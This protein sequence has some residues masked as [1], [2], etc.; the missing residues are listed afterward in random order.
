MIERYSRD[1]LDQSSVK[2]NVKQNK[3]KIGEKS[4]NKTWT[5][6]N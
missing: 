1:E 3:K 5:T 4:F 2:E 6:W